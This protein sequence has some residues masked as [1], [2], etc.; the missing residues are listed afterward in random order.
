MHLK[1]IMR[2][3]EAKSSAF[4]GR[5]RD[6]LLDR[7]IFNAL[8]EEKVLIEQWREHYNHVRPHSALGYIP[9]GPEARISLE[10]RSTTKGVSL[11][12]KIN[13]PKI[14]QTNAGL[15]G[16]AVVLMLLLCSLWG[17]NMAAIKIGSTMVA[18]VFSAFVRSAVA[19]LLLIGWM[20]A[21][22]VRLFPD[23]A[24]VFHGAVTGL[25]FGLEFGCIYLGLQH[26]MAS[27]GYVL[28]Y[29]HP[30]FVALGG[31][32]L[33]HDDK[34]SLNKVAGLLLAF[35][36]VVI[37]FAGDWGA[38]T[39]ETLPGDLLLLAGG[40][41]WGATTL[42]VK[43]FMPGRAEPMQT[44][45]YQLFFSAPILLVLGFALENQLWLGFSWE[46]AGALFYQ[47]VII[48]FASYL[49][50][51][52]LLHRHTASLLTS[53]TFLTPVLGVLISGVLF[54]GEPLTG[55]MMLALG[56]VTTGL[57]LA[58]PLRRVYPENPTQ[59]GSQ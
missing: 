20:R 13:A 38:A 17:G 30:F 32:F 28:L 59:A 19:S 10:S 54:L 49:V 45:F 39:I 27:R 21:R 42:Y 3:L 37:L 48:A 44:L 1:R 33:L 18:P 58:N 55:N 9:P 57:F 41:L 47:S 6:G 16:Y 52:E 23:R 12:A 29:T 50:W 11:R 2:L 4:H 46:G 25:L 7:E 15:P 43:R 22:S 51:F 31:H 24:T 8:L 34:L 40:A 5:L 56:V 53:F 26:T 36:G 14:S 35:G